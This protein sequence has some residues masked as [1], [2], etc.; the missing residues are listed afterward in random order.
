ME[1]IWKDI[2]EYEGLYQVS[3]LGNVKSLSRTITLEGKNQYKKYNAK[4]EIKGKFIKPSINKYGYYQMLLYK[5]KM[6]KNFLVHRL[7]AQAFIPNRNNKPTVNHIDGNK[8]NN[9]IKNLEW[10]TNKEQTYHSIN[11]L[12]NKHIIL[13]K[14]RIKGIIKCTKKVIRDDGKIYDSSKLASI[15]N[16]I[17]DKIIRK[18]CRG[19]IKSAGNHGWKY[20]EGGINESD[21]R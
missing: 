7:V 13:E 10:A 4:K 16:N 9:N 19:E 3:N 6:K 14:C 8:L 15:D 5:N 21:K 1:E 2:P 11:V 17:S 20:L 12:K 18:C